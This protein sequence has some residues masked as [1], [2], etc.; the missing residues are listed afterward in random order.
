VTNQGTDQIAATAGARARS[1]TT[2]PPPGDSTVAKLASEPE[3]DLL[4]PGTPE[5]P[6]FPPLSK[7]GFGGVGPAEPRTGSTAAFGRPAPAEPRAGSAKFGGVHTGGSQPLGAKLVGALHADV[8]QKLAM[9]QAPAQAARVMIA[10]RAGRSSRTGLES[11]SSQQDRP[12]RELVRNNRTD[13][14]YCVPRPSPIQEPDGD[15]VAAAIVR[16]GP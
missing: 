13:D 6:S 8:A 4:P 14:H 11:R 5:S 2:K 10:A 12:A 16:Q 9:R 1:N 7:G 15:A 3:P